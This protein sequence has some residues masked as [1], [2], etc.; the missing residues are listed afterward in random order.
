MAVFNLLALE[1][2]LPI[3]IAIAAITFWDVTTSQRYQAASCSRAVE[4][5]WSVTA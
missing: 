5:R 4:E 2:S 1:Y 3:I